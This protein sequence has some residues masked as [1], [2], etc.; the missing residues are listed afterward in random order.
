M[1]EEDKKAIS[2]FYKL[3]N[4]KYE[5]LTTYQQVIIFKR[6]VNFIFIMAHYFDKKS[7]A[8][9]VNPMQGP[10]QGVGVVR[11]QSFIFYKDGSLLYELDHDFQTYDTQVEEKKINKRSYHIHEEL[12]NPYLEEIGNSGTVMAKWDRSCHELLKQDTTPKSLDFIMNE[13]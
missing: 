1:P 11:T 2:D 3:H 6:T 5:G 10:D 7:N 8:K 4:I 9:Y 12:N 13:T